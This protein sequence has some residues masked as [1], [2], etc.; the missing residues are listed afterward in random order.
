MASWAQVHTYSEAFTSVGSS[1]D[2]EVT[3][4]VMNNIPVIVF[5]KEA[6]AR[7]VV[8]IRWGFPHPKD[9][10]RPQPIHARAEGIDTTR[11]FAEAFRDDQRGIVLVKT[12]NE[13]P[14]VEG[15][16]V[17]HTITP[18][19]EPALAA[20]VI[21]R[22]FE[23]E[24]L[25]APLLAC[26]LV[27]VPANDLIRTLPTD[28]MPAFLATEDWGKWLGEIPAPLEEVKACL[29]TVEGVN[30]HMEKEQR[31]AKPRKRKPTVSDPGGLL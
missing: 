1:D 26:C 31:A 9:R 12:F 13:A 29:K 20:A 14:D 27:T 24:G 16:T 6:G 21:W 11:A 25:P 5:D 28:R 7:R 3:F 23:L 8:P 18:G 10:H 2:R 4:R 22:R 19:Q 15:P 17:Q 30:W